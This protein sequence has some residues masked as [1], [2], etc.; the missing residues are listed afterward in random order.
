MTSDQEEQALRKSILRN[1][2]LVRQQSA[3]HGT[4]LAQAEAS[5]L[6]IGGRFKTVSPM[7]ITGAK[8][9]PQYPPEGS[10]ITWPTD[11]D[12]LGFAIDDQPVIGEPFEVE[13]AQRILDERSA[14]PP[15]DDGPDDGPVA[16]P[17]TVDLSGPSTNSS[18]VGIAPT[19]RAPA[20]TSAF[21]PVDEGVGA[22]TPLRRRL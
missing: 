22:S 1:D 18:E 14:V 2:E 12:Q 21:K 7:T 8:A 11:I 5:A 17:T 13:R 4:Y 15:A 20:L 9:V 10:G 19:T 16:L 6:D 3:G